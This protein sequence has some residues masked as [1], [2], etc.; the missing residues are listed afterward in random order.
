MTK[1]ATRVEAKRVL[2]AVERGW[3]GEGDMPRI[4]N[5]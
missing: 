3:R 1:D 2:V 5:G 4:E